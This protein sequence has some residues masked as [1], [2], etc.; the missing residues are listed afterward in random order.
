MSAATGADSVCDLCGERPVDPDAFHSVNGRVLLTTDGEGE[1]VPQACVCA[2]CGRTA[3]EV[4]EW[5]A[6]YDPEQL[7]ALRREDVLPAD[8]AEN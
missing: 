2:E 6:K 7:E 4:E 8:E 1:T 5:L 3:E